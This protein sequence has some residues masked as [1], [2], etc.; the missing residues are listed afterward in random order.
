M[1]DTI[2]VATDG[3]EQATKAVDLAADLAAKYGARVELV[4][5]LLPARGEAV[6]RLARGEAWIETVEVRQDQPPGASMPELISEDEG[7]EKDDKYPYRMRQ[8]IAERVLASAELTLREQGVREIVT[9][10]LDGD[11]SL[12]IL[13]RAR[14]VGADMIVMGSRGLSDIKGLVMGSVSH[15]VASLAPCTCVT[16][17]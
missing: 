16:V 14:K 5:V 8:A 2:L 4:H 10:V 6:A 9:A 3:S 15:K 1:I 13:D 17:T 11:P 12:A 7:A